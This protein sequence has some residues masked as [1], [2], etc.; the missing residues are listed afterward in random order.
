[1]A[2][3]RGEYFTVLAAVKQ[4]ALV[5]GIDSDM[6]YPFA[7]SEVNTP[8]SYGDETKWR[9]VNVRDFGWEIAHAAVSRRPPIPLCTVVARTHMYTYAARVWRLSIVQGPFSVAPCRTR[10]VT[11][12]QL[13]H[14]CTP[15]PLPCD[16]V[17]GG[18]E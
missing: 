16:Y 7:L 5:V 4:R 17:R 18:V 15:A 8:A 11:I 2:A 1:V 9:I 14:R 12:L 13:S 10:I 6:L 3:G